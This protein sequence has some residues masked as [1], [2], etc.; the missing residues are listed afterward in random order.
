MAVSPEIQ[1]LIDALHATPREEGWAQNVA[2]AYTAA[3]ASV[4]VELEGAAPEFVEMVQTKVVQE[5][6]RQHVDEDILPDVMAI[7]EAPPGEDF[8]EGLTER[9][10][11]W[12]TALTPFSDEEL[13]TTGLR[14][15]AEAEAINP[16]GALEMARLAREGS[17]A[18]LISTLLLLQEQGQEYA[19]QPTNAPGAEVA[20]SLTAEGRSLFDYVQET[21]YAA[22]SQ[23]DPI[24]YARDE[25]GEFIRDENGQKVLQNNRPFDPDGADGS[26]REGVLITLNPEEMRA[27]MRTEIAQDIQNGTF[28]I[29]GLTVADAERIADQLYENAFTRAERTGVDVGGSGPGLDGSGRVLNYQFRVPEAALAEAIDGMFLGENPV[30]DTTAQLGLNAGQF[31]E[32]YLGI[33]NDLGAGMTADHLIEHF[34]KLVEGH[35]DYT[36]NPPEEIPPTMAVPEHMREQFYDSIRQAYEDSRR[37]DPNDPDSMLTQNFNADIFGERMEER[38]GIIDAEHSVDPMNQDALDYGA[39]IPVQL[40]AETENGFQVVNEAGEVMF[41][42]SVED[43]FAIYAARSNGENLIM[44]EMRSVD[45]KEALRELLGEDGFTIRA[46][47]PLD[48]GLDGADAGISGY[49]ISAPETGNSFHVGFDAVPEASVTDE[50]RASRNDGFD[51]RDATPDLEVAPDFTI[52]EPTAEQRPTVAQMGLG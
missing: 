19:Y 41:E 10:S 30:L 44:D 43:G 12:P 8:A 13:E 11:D 40:G 51:T 47:S 48:A 20:G 38:F 4:P 36:V 22:N 27:L 18:D 7:T 52:G 39:E 42:I 49:Y 21:I 28:P 24:S 5:T 33:M 45:S 31:T 3:I 50:F 9:A 37:L 32:E 25:N 16:N 34:T 6:L 29:P 15:N 1:G 46:V 35:T 26:Y 14:R 23:L 17:Q 2:D